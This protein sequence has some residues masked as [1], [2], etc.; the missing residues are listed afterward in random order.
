M[1]K[2]KQWDDGWSVRRPYTEPW[3]RHESNYGGKYA[4]G[5]VVTPHGFCDVY[6]QD[7][8]DSF[9]R[10]RFVHKGRMHSRNYAPAPSER[11]LSRRAWQFVREVVG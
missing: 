1:A 5:C 11:A 7:G 6:W 10:I 8:R 3:D 4:T 2:R 9:A